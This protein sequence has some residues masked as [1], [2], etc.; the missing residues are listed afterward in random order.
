MKLSPTKCTL[1]VAAGKF[2]GYVVTQLGIEASAD[3]IKALVNIQSPRNSKEV[4]KLTG[5]VAALNRFIS[6]SLE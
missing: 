2:P 5:R 4:Q 6:R 3:Q 1:G